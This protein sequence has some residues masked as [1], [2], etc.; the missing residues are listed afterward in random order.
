MRDARQYFLSIEVEKLIDRSVTPVFSLLKLLAE[1]PQFGAKVGNFRSKLRHFVR[2][3][4][5][6]VRFFFTGDWLVRAGI[7]RV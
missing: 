7:I 5:Q 6:I 4:F 3:R 2:K 1:S